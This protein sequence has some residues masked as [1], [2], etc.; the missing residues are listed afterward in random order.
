[1]FGCNSNHWNHLYDNNFPEK[2]SIKQ[3]IKFTIIIF[4]QLKINK[5]TKNKLPPKKKT[6]PRNIIRTKSQTENLQSLL[7]A[8]F[9]RLS[10]TQTLRILIHERGYNIMA[11]AVSARFNRSGRRGA[12]A[13]FPFARP[14]RPF[15]K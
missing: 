8:D 5:L 15:P 6:L 9:F 13:P 10:S 7:A 3:P 4:I 2:F 12:R 14:A 11:F 1:M